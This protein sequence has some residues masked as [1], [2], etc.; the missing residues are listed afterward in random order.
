M[1]L[2]RL[3]DAGLSLDGAMQV[4]ACLHSGATASAPAAGSRRGSRAQQWLRSLPTALA[5]A[6][7]SVPYEYGVPRLSPG[8]YVL[9]HP[10]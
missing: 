6:D 4:Q 2:E 10:G 5:L 3:L 9:Y 7:G 8:Q 1:D